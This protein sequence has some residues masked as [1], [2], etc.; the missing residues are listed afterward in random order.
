MDSRLL[1]FS[2]FM[3]LRRRHLW[4]WLFAQN[5]LRS[6]VG[7]IKILFFNLYTFFGLQ[8]DFLPTAL[9][10]VDSTRKKTWKECWLA[11]WR[12]RK[13]VPIAI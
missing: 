4:Q 6:A 3:L 2:S 9:I 12:L 5:C 8:V 13:C 11:V 1:D 10:C 7:T